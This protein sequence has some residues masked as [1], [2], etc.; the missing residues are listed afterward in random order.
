MEQA[1]LGE[2]LFHFWN[3]EDSDKAFEIFRSIMERGL[4]LTCGCG[5]QLGRFTY[6]GKNGPQSIDL[7]Q[8]SRV[9]F[10][11]I[12]DDK[13]EAHARRYGKC[14]LGFSRATILKWGGLPA[15]YLPNHPGKDS[16]QERGIAFVRGLRN[17]DFAIALLQ[18]LFDAWKQHKLEAYDFFK[19]VNINHKQLTVDE[20]QE[21][22][23]SAKGVVNNLSSFIKEMSPS[24]SDDHSYIY[25]REWR[26]VSGMEIEG[27]SIFRA[28][29]SKEKTELARARPDWAKA[30]MPTTLL[31]NHIYPTEPMLDKFHYFNGIPGGSTVSQAVEVIYVPDFDFKE[32]VESYVNGN[33]GRFNPKV[34]VR[35]FGHGSAT[36]A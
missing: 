30:M 12:P 32:K 6:S 9:C 33:T 22:M 35:V 5:S 10:T 34:E 27:K 20:V 2:R 7:L 28:L 21:L 25:E 29:T 19:T 24:E 17:A 3:H 36:P 14:G 26:I 8:E 13:L 1:Y 11:D 4:L 18:M 16:L 15:W 23:A 31:P